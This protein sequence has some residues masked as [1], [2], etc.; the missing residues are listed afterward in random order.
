MAQSPGPWRIV[1]RA[2]QTGTKR[3]TVIDH[4][5]RQ[6]CCFENPSADQEA[7]AILIAAAPE[8]LIA[9]CDVLAAARRP[10][11]FSEERYHEILDA[12]EAAI[13]KAGA[14]P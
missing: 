11:D 13:H 5:T 14:T 9:C 10:Q 6:V 7:N 4:P 2:N 1:R 12:A 8:L 3:I